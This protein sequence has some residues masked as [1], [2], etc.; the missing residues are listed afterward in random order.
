MPQT[1]LTPA[2]DVHIRLGNPAEVIDLRHAVLRADQS[3]EDAVYE[4]DDHPDTR[5]VVAL[6]GDGRVVGCATVHPATWEGQ[7]TWRLRGMAIDPKLQ[8]TGIGRA[9]LTYLQR[10]LRADTNVHA[11]WCNARVPAVGF[12]QKL[13]WR[14]V[15]DVFDVPPI[16]P[17][18]RMTKSLAV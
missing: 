8:G 10:V 2:G 5:H 13:G 11:M 7:P 15:S 3:R 6:L 18:V 1:I 4:G 12:Y 9:M 17:H 14:V 16:G